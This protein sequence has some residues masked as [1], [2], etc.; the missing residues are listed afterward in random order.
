MCPLEGWLYC[1]NRPKRVFSFA[2]LA[3]TTFLYIHGERTIVLHTCFIENNEGMLE[4]PS[5][6]FW[7][8]KDEIW[9]K[10]RKNQL[11][12]VILIVWWPIFWLS[13]PHH[14]ENMSLHTYGWTH[15]CAW[16]YSFW[17][18]FFFLHTVMHTLW[19][20]LLIHGSAFCTQLK[21]RKGSGGLNKSG[22]MATLPPPLLLRLPHGAYMGLGLVITIFVVFGR[23]TPSP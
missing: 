16:H 15:M 12:P 14:R 11:F 13:V 6:K 19:R 8:E 21:P 5:P 18:A 7:P 22:A 23:P 20:L 3:W 4:D 17:T 1:G 9:W 2:Q 10:L